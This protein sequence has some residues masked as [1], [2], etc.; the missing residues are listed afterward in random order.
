MKR[1]TTVLITAT[2]LSLVCAAVSSAAEPTAKEYLSFFKPIVGDWNV[3]FRTGGADAVCQWKGDLSPTKQC[4]IEHFSGIDAVPAFDGVSGFDPRTRKWKSLF[5]NAKGDA[6]S[7]YCQ[8]AKLEGKEATFQVEFRHVTAD[9][10]ESQEKATWR[11]KIVSDNR[12]EIRATDRIVDGEKQ[13]DLES[14]S[15]RK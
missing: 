5:F 11:F 3:T 15:E 4:L 14:I 10:K 8:A 9:G 2:M 7:R 12:W 6:V 13:P 1:F